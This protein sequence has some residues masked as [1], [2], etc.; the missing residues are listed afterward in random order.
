MTDDSTPT[1]AVTGAA[2]Y[3]GSRVVALFQE[4]HPEWSVRALDNFYLGDV[5]QI[6]DVTVEHVDIRHRDRLDDA[7]D[8][9]DVVCHLAAISGVD[10]CE[11][12][13]DLAYEVNV[14][15]TSNVAWWCRKTGAGLAF[16]FSMAVL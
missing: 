12:R 13:H 16:P 11:T 10:D 3:I 14:T 1:V 15:G 2:G 7:L 6:G 9:A 8:G 4:H 5:R